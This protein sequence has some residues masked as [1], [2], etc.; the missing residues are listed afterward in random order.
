M[1]WSL[2]YYNLACYANPASGIF[3]HSSGDSSFPAE[4]LFE[5]TDDDVMERFEK[6]IAVLS[7]LPALVVA[8]LG[9]L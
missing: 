6:N 9:G 2:E 3:K 8:M 5:Y 1:D 7:E 4:R